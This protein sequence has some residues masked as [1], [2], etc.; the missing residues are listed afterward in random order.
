M[1]VTGEQK[2]FFKEN[3]YLVIRDFLS[4]EEVKS[5]QTWAQEVHDW[6]PTT[7]SEF[8][9]YEVRHASASSFGQ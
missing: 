8:M 2:S 6:Q 4:P 9:P 1:A 3:G 7:E 5:L